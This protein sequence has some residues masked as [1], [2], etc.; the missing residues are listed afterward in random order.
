MKDTAAIDVAVEVLPP[1]TEPG[2]VRIDGTTPLAEIDKIRDGLKL[3]QRQALDGIIDWLKVPAQTSVVETV[4][5]VLTGSAGTGKSHTA[6]SIIQSAIALGLLYPGG[7]IGVAPT[8]AAAANLAD[9]SG[10]ETKTVHSFLGLRMQKVKLTPE[11]K[12]ELARLREVSNTLEFSPGDVAQLALL[13]SLE[14]AQQEKRKE[15]RPTLNAADFAEKLAYTLIIIDEAYMLPEQIVR[16][17]DELLVH[18]GQL[19][20]QPK[21]LMLGDPAQLPPIKEKL[22]L[23]SKYFHIG[24]LSEVVRQD[25]VALSYVQA[26]RDSIDA[27]ELGYLHQEYLSANDP[28]FVRLSQ[29][30]IEEHFLSQIKEVGIANVRV[31]TTSNARVRELND[32]LYR[33]TYPTRS[34]DQPYATGDL[35]LTKGPIMRDPLFPDKPGANEGDI[36]FPTSTPISIQRALTPMLTRSAMGTEYLAS[37]LFVFS[38]GNTMNEIVAIHPLQI[39]QWEEEKALLFKFACTT[40]GRSKKK[41]A[42]GQEG[43]YAKQA[44]QVFGLKNW[45]N[46]VPEFDSPEERS[47]VL[48]IWKRWEQWSYGGLRLREAKELSDDEYKDIGRMLWREYFNLVQLADNVSLSFCSTVHFAQGQTIKLVILDFPKFLPRTGRVDPNSTWDSQKVLYTAASRV[49]GEG[50]QLVFMY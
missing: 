4:V 32:R 28:G 45:S 27:S 21:I 40:R 41:G 39:G 29:P 50:S 20:V 37:N 14:H 7:V 33:R 49:G 6:Y 16:V 2:L 35:L 31:L 43:D 25:G 18:N 1:D 3:G 38:A 5:A 12:R 46:T 8:H 36:L 13:E 44:W 24:H 34:H 23:V 26:V 19:P 9:F 10:I 42:R 11:Q 30:I 22:S 47:R 15:L 48:E 17:L